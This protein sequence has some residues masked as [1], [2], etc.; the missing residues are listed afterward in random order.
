MTE[1]SPKRSSRPSPW[2]LALALPVAVVLYYAI[3][4]G[5]AHVIDDDPAFDPPHA[6]G[7][8]R[9]VAMAA[10]L[11]LRE[12]DQHKWVANDPFFVPSW[13]LDDMPAFQMGLMA[14][15]SRFAA[16]LAQASAG[17]TDESDPELERAAGFLKYPGTV[18]KFDPRTSWAPT[19]SS[20]KQY[21]SAARNLLVF[22]QRLATG[23]ARFERRPEMLAFLLRG[24]AGAMD[25]DGARLADFVDSGHGALLSTKADNVFFDT[26][27]RLYAQTMIVGE[28]GWDFAPL[29]AE[30]GLGDKWQGLL[31]AFNATQGMH[32]WMILNGSAQSMLVPN[33]LSNLGFR[34]L[35]ARQR[36][37]AV[38]EA[39]EH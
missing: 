36:L 13:L 28:L 19:A 21:R 16:D 37:G 31:A 2:W 35:A 12:V 23:Q 17:S 11:V 8:S 10:G 34:A 29:I 14:A 5:L 32:P 30:R 7:E 38:I 27:G 26:K 9:A 18:W 24:I 20:E 39:L 4:M 15:V 22:N 6:P 1:A 33:H 3:G 25:E